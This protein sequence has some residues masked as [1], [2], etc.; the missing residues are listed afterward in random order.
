MLALVGILAVVGAGAFALRV[1]DV[2]NFL[3]FLGKPTTSTPTDQIQT[4]SQRVMLAYIGLRIWRD[5]PILGVGFERSTTGYGP[6]LADAK[7]RYPDEAPSSFPSKQH[8]W[9]VQNFWLQ[10]LADLGVVGL[11]L[12]L[13]TFGTGLVLALRAPAAVGFVALVAAVVDPRRRRD[14]ERARDRR[15]QPAAGAH[16]ARARARRR[17][18]GAHGMSEW[19]GADKR[20]PRKSHYNWSLREPLARWLEEEGRAAAGLRVLDVGCGEKP[21]LPYFDGASEYVGV[22]VDESAHADLVGAVERLPLADASFDLVLCIQV[23][24]HVDDPAR[25]VR[26]LHRVVRPGGRVL[27]ATHG[28]YVFHPSPVDHWRWTHTG[29]ARLFEEN[30][31]W[32]S[33]E[34]AAGAGHGVVARPARRRVRRP[35]RAAPPRRVARPGRELDD[36]LGRAAGSTA[37][38]RRCAS[39]GPAR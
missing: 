29:L 22:D 2:T 27:V 19:P 30:G 37:A 4:G 28:T 15:R 31:E 11:L 20:K 33:V 10:T 13:A 9:G 23:L 14:V 3:S 5:H 18:R 8:A 32:R 17:G 39:R 24:E 38:P 16:V 34:V 35:G 1:S 6:Y 7:R 36:Q 12:A 25:A 21:Y 26:E